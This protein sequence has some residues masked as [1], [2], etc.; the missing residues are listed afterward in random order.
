MD[1][2]TTPSP[3]PVVTLAALLESVEVSLV[4]PEMA[5]EVTP[6]VTLPE[7]VEELAVVLKEEIDILSPHA[8]EIDEEEDGVRGLRTLVNLASW[9]SSLEYEERCLR[10][11]NDQQPSDEL[12]EKIS[13]VYTKKWQKKEQ[14][15]RTLDDLREIGRQ[16]EKRSREAMNEALLALPVPRPLKKLKAELKSS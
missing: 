16:R 13:E 1:T 7:P 5:P 8:L 6:E 14:H 2:V 11:L 12:R 15:K 9:I 3:V 4:V 10:K